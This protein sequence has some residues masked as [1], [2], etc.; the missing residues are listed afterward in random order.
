MSDWLSGGGE[1]SL[2]R[3]VLTESYARISWVYA[4][5]NVIAETIG[6]RHLGPVQEAG[7]HGLQVGGDLAAEL[8]ERIERDSHWM[9][10]GH[11]RRQWYPSVEKHAPLWIDGYI[12]GD[13]TKPFKTAKRRVFAAVR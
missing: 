12:K 8:R 5:V 11:W 1:P 10:T 4:S 6:I 9:V 2:K 7:D 13:T 3:F